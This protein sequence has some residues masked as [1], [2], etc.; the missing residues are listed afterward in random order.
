[1][2][3]QEFKK[4]AEAVGASI[5]NEMMAVY[6]NVEGVDRDKISHA[7]A[8]VLCATGTA[9]NNANRTFDRG[10]KG[11]VD[12]KE[13]K[14]AKTDFFKKLFSKIREDFNAEISAALKEFNEA[15]PQSVKDANKA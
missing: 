10:V 12:M 15:V 7:V 9:K 4:A 5:C 1:M 8:K 13:Y 6:Y 11:F 2:N 3:K 14:K